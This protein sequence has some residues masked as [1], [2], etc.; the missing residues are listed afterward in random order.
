M[1]RVFFSK[2][3]RNQ[4]RFNSSHDTI[5]EPPLDF[6]VRRGFQFI[7]RWNINCNHESFIERKQPLFSVFPIVPHV[8]DIV[9]VFEHI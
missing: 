7:P 6:H 8:L 1:K 2:S 3:I 4:K 5:D 9:I